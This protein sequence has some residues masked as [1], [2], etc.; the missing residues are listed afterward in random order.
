[1]W[2][3]GEI[4]SRDAA[5]ILAFSIIMLNTDQHNPQVRVRT[6]MSHIYLKAVLTI[7]V[8]TDDVG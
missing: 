6:W 8:E 2:I 1:M 7:D 4:K 5:D 3:E